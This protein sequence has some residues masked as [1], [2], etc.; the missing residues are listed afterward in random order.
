MSQALGMLEVLGFS[1]AMA[2][3]DKACKTAEIKI[4]GIDCNNPV[5]GDQAHIPVVVQ[6]KFS[7][8]ISDVKEALAIAE[9]EAIKYIPEK[10]VMIRMV[11]SMSKELSGLLS[12]GKVKRKAPR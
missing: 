5:A 9:L 4:E 8:G 3:M 2:A 1:V 12:L 11:P 10:D 7:G 6:V